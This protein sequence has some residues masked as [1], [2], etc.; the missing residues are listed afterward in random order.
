[1]EIKHWTRPRSPLTI[2][3]KDWKV[4]LQSEIIKING[5]LIIE[6]HAP[7]VEV[8]VPELDI[9]PTLIGSHDFSK[10]NI[11]TNIISNHPDEK[12]R[13]DRYWFAYIVKGGKKT[14]VKVEI[15]LKNIKH[16]NI[17]TIPECLW[18]EI[19]WIN[20]GPF[21]RLKLR[22]GFPISIKRPK[23]KNSS[24][25]CFINNDGYDLLPIKTHLL[26][27]LDDPIEVLK[28]YTSKLILPGDILT[29]GET[30]LAVIQG[31]YLHPELIKPSYLSTILCRSFHPTSSLATACGMQSLINI[32]GP[33][34][35]SVAWVIAILMKLLGIKGVFYRLAGSQARLI[36]DI[37]G[38]TPP[39][40]QTIVLG[41]TSPQQICEKVASIIG[42]E[43][44]VV[45]VNDLGRV[46]ILA[47]SNY[48]NESLVMRALKKNPAGNSNEQTP[49]VLVR[50]K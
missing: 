42:I 30:P 7:K 19:F 23:P 39:Y 44:A 34:R 1:M 6:N 17:L 32:V 26:G 40:D 14:K 8:M 16:Q 46:K 38:T 28:E 11:E 45:D 24:E 15:T 3:G 43:V 27:P 9:K 50:P 49:I 10:V 47:S 4:D 13:K 22:Q 41:P 20:Y 25:V 2:E 48:C 33:S 37:T 21:G 36:D 31:R 5:W 12:A 29:I 18:L 35:V